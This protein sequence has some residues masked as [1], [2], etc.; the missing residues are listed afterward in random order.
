M[1]AWRVT[2]EM[3]TSYYYC[4]M[5]L[6]ANDINCEFFRFIEDAGKYQAVF[7]PGGHNLSI[8]EIRA[9]E[10][11]VLEGGKLYLSAGGYFTG[12]ERI[13]GVR[14]LDI[15]LYNNGGEMEVFGKN[16]RLGAVKGHYPL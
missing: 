8:N 2:E 4:F 16:L 5:L 9:L 14:S 15:R 13:C 6:K 1:K 3:A 10:K 12:Y 11:Y 7:L